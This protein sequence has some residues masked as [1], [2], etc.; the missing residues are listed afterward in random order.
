M[1]TQARVV[2]IGGG[3]VGVSTLYHLAK[4]GWSDVVLVERTE[5]T[6]GSTWHAAG[7]LPLFN[8]SYSVGQ[9]H[10]YSV[11]LYK[12][13]EE[14][15]GQ[16]VS[17]HV[18]GNLRLAETQERMDE[19]RKYCG[20]ANTIGV[21]Y[22]L[23][24]PSEVKELWPLA[25]VDDLVGAIYHPDDGHIAPADL[26]T[27]LSIGARNRG[28]E[29]YRQT[30][31]TGVTQKENG[32]WIVHTSKGDI[33][34]EHVVCATGNYARQTGALFGLDVPA[35]PVEHQYIVTEPHPAL[36]QR[37]KEGKPELPVLRPSDDAYYFREERQ[38]FLLGPYEK[39][40]P[41]CFVDGVPDSFGQDLFPG[42][43]ERLMPHVEA[44]MER[45]PAFTEVGIKDIINGPI[46]YTPDGNPLVGPAWGV[47]NVW[48]NE[49]HSFGITAAGGAGRYLAEWIIEG[50][51]SIELI[52]VDPRRY[53]AYANK[54][55]TKLKNEE[56]YEHVF[57]IH[58]PDEE[59]PAAR[60]AKM[61]PIHDKL[62]AAG[63]VWGQRYGWERPNW[64]A[65]EGVERK[66][67]W[68]FRRTNYFE[69]VGNEARH[70]REKA[71]LID[72]TSFSKFEVSGPGAEA[73]LDRL[74]ANTIPKKV[75]RMS[76]SHALTHSGGVRSEFTITK[77]AENRFY[78]ISSGSAERFDWDFLFKNLPDDG[79]VRLDNI[80]GSRG[81]FVLSGPNARDILQQ[82][83]DSDLS[84]A[85]FPWLTGQ[86]I[87]VGLASDVRTLRVNFVGELGWE[88][89]HPIEYQR[90]IFD[91]IMQAGKEH[92][93]GLVG[94][95]AMD[96]L[97]IEKSYRMWAKDLSREY[98]AFEAGLDRFVRL[99]KGEFTGREALVRQQQEGLPR[100]FVTMEV[101]PEARNGRPIADA[102]GNEP[103]YSNGNMIGR[104]TSGV[105]GHN[106]E[107]SL[108]LGYVTPE[109][110]EPGTELEIEILRDRF[111]ARVVPESPWDPENERLRA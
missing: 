69:H 19:Y 99:N 87:N 68:S 42:D 110:A 73:Y 67:V 26:T 62:D 25:E 39:G 45:I 8:M 78:L 57:V 1:K 107:R 14:E 95:R 101:F 43:L 9:I 60:P 40:A 34:C 83:T 81:V 109:F 86:A 108:A 79:S 58:Y 33:T 53:G 90:H 32:E 16:N 44:A 89:H 4:F 41:A 59:R 28:A 22:E 11:D 61:S 38:G 10:K 35:I 85:A 71:G 88:L 13:L 55:Y 48:L 76:L 12:S 5:L 111:Q 84:N 80:T 96:A 52:D 105:Y 56:A 75:G 15:T 7:L 31:V 2:V 98:T 91:E 72:L 77:L 63:A 92:E 93:L 94:I 100:R 70:M 106:V 104:A 37:Q 102:G 65:P 29:I 66:D 21:P 54:R 24:T 3:A 49:G 17:F 46:S 23:I 18:N 64:F 74:V 82:L 47:K 27:A 50:E 97:R 36:V 51:P 30:P 103:I 20:T 6:A